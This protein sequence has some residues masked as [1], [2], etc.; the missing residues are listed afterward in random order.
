MGVEWG[1]SGG[2]IGF[3]LVAVG[4]SLPELVTVIVAARKEETGLIIGN[5]FGSN[6]FNSLAVA[7]AMGLVGAEQI[8]DPSLTTAKGMVILS[9]I[10]LL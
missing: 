3:S 8:N 5:L 6:V 7:G 10:L 9:I 2:F 1:L 4:T